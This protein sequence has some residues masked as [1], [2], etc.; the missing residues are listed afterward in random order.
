ML[1]ETHWADVA[2]LAWRYID[3]GASIIWA[4]TGALRAAKQR[5]DLA[6]L[7]AIALVSSTGGGLLRDGLFLQAGPPALIRTP[8]YIAIAAAASL[9]VWAF[10]HRAQAWWLL[11]R[12][13]N[14]ADAFGLG[15]FAVVGMQLSAALDVNVVGAMLVGVVNAVGGGILGSLLMREVPEV[16]RPGHWMA[17][18]VLPGCVL[19]E[20]LTVG[21]GVGSNLA[22]V[23]TLL[24]VAVLRWLSIRYSFR[25]SPPRGLGTTTTLRREARA[26]RRLRRRR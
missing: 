4:T 22:A 3:L 23:P 24:L 2:G 25:T 9:L 12:V 16:F 13:S 26:R 18:A 10:A 6:G 20:T 19:Y 11:D 15:G 8:V 5:Y 7:F 1:D 14:I 21:F 17:L